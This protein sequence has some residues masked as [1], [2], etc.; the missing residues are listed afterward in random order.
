MSRKKTEVATPENLVFA[1]DEE[2]N[3]Q[4]RTLQEISDA[5]GISTAALSNYSRSVGEPTNANLEKL[6]AYF[7]V[8]A[9]FLRGTGL[10]KQ[11]TGANRLE[12]AKRFHANAKE[13]EIFFRFTTERMAEISN[14]RRTNKAH[15]AFIERM[16]K[17]RA[18]QDAER[19]NQFAELGRA[20]EQIPAKFHKEAVLWLSEKIK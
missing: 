15:V 20:F 19:E 17:L 2:L 11:L 4:K 8:E 3:T 13:K 5:T 6:A 12:V 1:L 7:N 10:Y 14:G 18:E 9:D 16:A